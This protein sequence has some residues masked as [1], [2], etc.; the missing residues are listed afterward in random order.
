LVSLVQVDTEGLGLADDF[1]GDEH[2]NLAGVAGGGSFRAALIQVKVA[3]VDAEAGQEGTPE[4][5]IVAGLGGGAAFCFPLVGMA[6]P[7]GLDLHES[8]ACAGTDE[9]RT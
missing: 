1:A 3:G 5:L 4:L 2:V 6:A 9:Q 7:T 8:M